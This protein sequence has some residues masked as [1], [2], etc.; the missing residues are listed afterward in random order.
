MGDDHLRRCVVEELRKAHG[1]PLSPDDLFERCGGAKAT[2]LNMES[3]MAFVGQH[4]S[5]AVKTIQDAGD[6]NS[7][8]RYALHVDSSRKTGTLKR[9]GT[10][11][12]SQSS[13][14][15]GT[16]DVVRFNPRTDGF[17]VFCHIVRK[18]SSCSQDRT[19]NWNVIRNQYRKETGR[20]LNAEELNSMC[21]TINMTKHDLLSTHLSSVVEIMD[22]RGQILRPASPFNPKTPS[23]TSSNS[24][25][26]QDEQ[27]SPPHRAA[28]DVNHQDESQGSARRQHIV[29]QLRKNGVHVD[30]NG[31]IVI[32]QELSPT[33]SQNSEP[34]EEELMAYMTPAASFKGK[35]AP[36]E[37]TSS[38]DS[39][40]QR[41]T[42][43]SG[44]TSFLSVGQVLETSGE[45]AYLTGDDA[46]QTPESD[47][48][49]DFS[50][51]RSAR[52][53]SPGRTH[54]IT[55][56]NIDESI[57]YQE[58][59]ENSIR[60]DEAD[61]VEVDEEQYDDHDQ[62]A[63][64]DRR[65]SIETGS[66]II[67][68]E[69]EV[70]ENGSVS[71]SNSSRMECSVLERHDEDAMKDSAGEPSAAPCETGAIE[72]S[73]INPEP[74]VF[75]PY[76]PSVSSERS[77]AS[78][79]LQEME[80]K[81]I[82]PNAP[83]I[84]DEKDTFEKKTIDRV[85]NSMEGLQPPGNSFD[86]GKI[87]SE[88]RETVTEPVAP[89]TPVKE[90]LAFE[91]ENEM[92]E[93]GLPLN[94]PALPEEEASMHVRERVDKFEHIQ[95]SLN[96]SSGQFH[97]KELVEN[98]HVMEVVH[99]LEKS[100]HHEKS[101]EKPALSH[102][103][104]DELVKKVN[105]IET[106]LNIEKPKE[107]MNE[108]TCRIHEMPSVENVHVMKAIH[109][110]ESPKRIHDE[111]VNESSDHFPDRELM[112]HVSVKDTVH[113]LEKPAS[114]SQAV[115]DHHDDKLFPTDVHVHDTVHS[116]EHEYDISIPVCDEYLKM[117]SHRQDAGDAPTAEFLIDETPVTSEQDVAEVE[118]HVN[119][120]RPEET[121]CKLVTVALGD[122][123]VKHEAEKVD[124][125][126]T[127]RNTQTI[128]VELNPCTEN[129]PKLTEGVTWEKEFVVASGSAAPESHRPVDYSL[130]T[131]S[132]EVGAV[133]SMEKE[134]SE[135]P[136]ITTEQIGE[137]GTTAE[138]PSMPVQFPTDSNPEH[139]HV[140]RSVGHGQLLLPR[141][142]LMDCCSIL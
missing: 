29:E 74:S 75:V 109:D 92:N 34:I 94:E 90:K 101:Q 140:A 135:V 122:T 13:S 86:S 11:S 67:E 107:S 30:E 38:D 84:H 131:V 66:P 26:S 134:D 106:V 87:S 27:F 88:R 61:I 78:Y 6:E 44:N 115:V 108:S 48:S 58:E 105:V 25:S 10:R 112:E 117:A 126:F 123:E 69:D 119:L 21:G 52:E 136:V 47:V 96:E 5:R 8:P 19:I 97:E 16:P 98:V 118:C 57:V 9:R 103:C 60:H 53:S 76:S 133:K 14:R 35:V 79:Y 46:V 41:V 72:Q 4:C 80:K 12:N 139:K 82:L 23:Q 43:E 59:E 116:L 51:D 1:E 32:P 55:L 62:A 65:T 40:D 7:L 63:D 83:S 3:F 110:L 39:P 81:I 77:G 17:L 2:N 114:E 121:T 42:L 33:N 128:V 99:D 93:E 68:E 95:D 100:D 45:G 64:V 28:I 18:L 70:E 49:L 104:E 137:L 141:R 37:K 71:E 91:E 22:S 56:C 125:S 102:C 124:Q 73:E 127:A 113:N 31:R 54:E 50:N 142:R 132:S 89:I 15:G 120:S 20:H 85:E 138:L 130:D 129:K 111:N 24:R 36:S